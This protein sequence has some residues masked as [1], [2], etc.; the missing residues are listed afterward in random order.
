M[1]LFALGSPTV[2]GP[3]IVLSKLYANS[4]MVFLNDRIPYGHGCNDQK[5]VTGLP[6]SIRFVS[7]PKPADAVPKQLSLESCGNASSASGRTAVEDSSKQ[8]SCPV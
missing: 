6:G 3:A 8:H 5:V 7:A 1:I 2:L 4:M